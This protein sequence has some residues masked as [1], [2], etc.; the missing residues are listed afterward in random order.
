MPKSSGEF[1]VQFS[2][3]P[4]KRRLRK[5]NIIIFRNELSHM[6]KRCKVKLTHAS[7]D[8]REGIN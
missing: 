5:M 3:S 7:S 8:M 1:Q 4:A 2:R 6:T